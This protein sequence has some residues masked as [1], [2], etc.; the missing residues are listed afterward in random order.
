VRAE[1]V[2]FRALDGCPLG[3]VLYASQSSRR[4]AD[5][6]VFA[7][8]T[9]I[10]SAVYRAFLTHLAHAGIPVLAFD[11][12]GIGA[13]RPASLR[14]FEAGFEDWA[15]YDAGAAIAWMRARYPHARLAGIGHSAGAMIIGANEAATRLAQMVAIAPHTGYFGDHGTSLRFA[16]RYG[17]R[18]AARVITPALGYFPAGLVGAEDLPA[19][20]AMQWSACTNPGFEGGLAQGDPD[21]GRRV[22]EHAANL[23]LPTLVLSFHDDT[24]AT[25]IGVRR[26]L[27]GFRNLLAIRRIVTRADVRDRGIG[28]FGFFRRSLGPALWPI[29][30]RFVARPGTRSLERAAP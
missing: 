17:W 16:M 28:H 4:V 24:W 18:T 7:A 8:G 26:F 15:E 5:A 27:H 20:V 22:L 30:T 25:E 6:A 23:R 29:V 10:R 2:R 19:R 3:G 21:R 9:G 13:S 1:P 12:R 11:Y 14:G